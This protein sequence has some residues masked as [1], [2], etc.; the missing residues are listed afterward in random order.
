MKYFLIALQ[1][2]T[3][4]PVKIK[5]KIEDKDF[6]K[7]LL[8][9]PAVG[10]IIG[11]ILSI[12]AFFFSR[13]APFLSVAVILVVSV[14]LT[15]GIH[16][17]GFADT[18]DGFYASHSKEQTLK[19]MRDSRIGVMGVIGIVCVFLLKFALLSSFS[20]ALLWRAVIIMAVFSRWALS[21][22]CS[23][24]KYARQ[25]GKAEFFIKYADKRAVL[26]GGIFTLA[27]FLIFIG[28]KG[29]TVFILSWIFVFLFVKYSEKK[30]GGITGDILGAVN[31]I[32]EV[33]TLLFTAIL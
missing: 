33:S 10:L 26:A 23:L 25:K 14:V 3:I 6:G 12:T 7:S 32:G 16:L 18:C 19:I 1:F 13:F 11:V 4:L 21:F 29:V 5:A 15:G 9:F 24:S 31:E 28:T 22:A 30:I 17:D 2:L 8:Y 27:T 20:P